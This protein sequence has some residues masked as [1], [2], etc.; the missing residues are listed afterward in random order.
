MQYKKVL[1]HKTN[2]FAG[3]FATMFTEDAQKSV[4]AI[5]IPMLVQNFWVS[6]KL[7]KQWLLRRIH[8][9][10]NQLDASSGNNNMNRLVNNR[11]HVFVGQ[12]VALPWHLPIG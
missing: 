3:R 6:P 5:S 11:I 12:L 10:F 1:V 9:I 4:I 8:G 7:K 2:I